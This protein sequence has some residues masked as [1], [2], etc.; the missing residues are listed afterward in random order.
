V[1]GTGTIDYAQVARLIGVD[2]LKL[3]EKDGKLTGSAPVPVPQLGRTFN[4]SGTA[5]IAVQDNVLQ[6]RFADVTAAELPDNPLVKALIEAQ[7]KRLGLDLKV[8]ALP[9]KLQVKSVLPTP[10][11]LRVTAGANEVAFGSGGL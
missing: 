4:L 11:G 3:T 5:T 7:V 8:P 9:L 10:G 2:G 1:T 6:V